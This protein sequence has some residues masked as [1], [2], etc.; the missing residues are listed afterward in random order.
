MVVFSELFSRLAAGTAATGNCSTVGFET[1]CSF[2]NGITV[3][4]GINDCEERAGTGSVNSDD[5]ADSSSA[6]FS[7][8]ESPAKELSATT[9][10][11]SG[12]SFIAAENGL[13]SSASSSLC[14]VWSSVAPKY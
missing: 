9:S 1:P 8:I 13:P 3:D 11:S 10:A 5:W 14:N 2:G 6:D 7:G 12:G 4:S